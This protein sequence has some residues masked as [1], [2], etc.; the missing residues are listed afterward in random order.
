MEISV[1]LGIHQ[2]TSMLNSFSLSLHQA[3]LCLHQCYKINEE[4]ICYV[5]LTKN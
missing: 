5:I 2:F 4:G 3:L 1:L